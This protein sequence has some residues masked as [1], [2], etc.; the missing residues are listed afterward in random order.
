MHELRAQ[1]TH[2]TPGHA[3]LSRGRAMRRRFAAW[4]LRCARLS[5]ARRV[6]TH[7]QDPENT[8]HRIVGFLWSRSGKPFPYTMRR[9][10]ET[11]SVHGRY[12]LAVD[13]GNAYLEAGLAGLGVLCGPFRVTFAGLQDVILKRRRHI[14]PLLGTVR[15]HFY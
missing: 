3:V 15:M 5:A 11:I 4:R 14:A 8:D 7:P 13:D 6:P 1:V 10:D 12:A 9:D 2:L